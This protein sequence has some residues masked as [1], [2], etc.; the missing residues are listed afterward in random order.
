MKKMLTGKLNLSRETL[1][2]LDERQMDAVVGGLSARCTSGGS[3]PTCS[4]DS[5]ATTTA[6][7]ACC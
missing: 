6:N 5:C 1:R 4:C 2:T 7:S 3:T